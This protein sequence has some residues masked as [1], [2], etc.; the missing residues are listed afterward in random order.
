M[1]NILW[2]SVLSTDDAKYATLDIAN[3]Y[4]G[5]PLD[6]YEYMKMP[7]DIFPQHIKE[8]YDLDN[9]AY[10]GYAW[11]EIKK[12]IYGLPQ[13]GMLANKQLQKKLPKHG[14]FEVNHTPGLWRH[15]TCPV[16]FSLVVD[17][18]GVK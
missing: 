12:A 4:L 13:A 5:T 14:Y 6:R 10:Q 17:N 16:Q 15:V 7:L 9:M 18:F 3:F 11:L 1:S 2:N 8:Q